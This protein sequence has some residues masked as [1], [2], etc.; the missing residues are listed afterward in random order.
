MPTFVIPSQRLKLDTAV[1]AITTIQRALW[2][3][4]VPILDAVAVA[5]YKKRAK[6]AML[7]RTI[8]WLLLGI[9]ALIALECLGRQWDRI[10]VAATAAVTLAALF[11]WLVSSHDLRWMTVGYGAYRSSQAVPPHVSATAN[12]LLSCGVCEERMGVEYLKTDPILFV[13]DAEQLPTVRYDLII[14]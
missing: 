10:A 3:L 14:W 13:E 11:S 1:V 9:A 2:R 4:D 8:R 12:A 5:E 6:T 7:W